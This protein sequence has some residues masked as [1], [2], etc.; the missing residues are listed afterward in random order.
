MK[1]DARISVESEEERTMM[2][3]RIMSL[4]AVL[5]FC[6][7]GAWGADLLG[8]WKGEGPRWEINCVI[9]R[10]AGGYL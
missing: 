3:N 7:T 8:E 10:D 6:M 1:Y 2:K 4:C 9:S 5:V